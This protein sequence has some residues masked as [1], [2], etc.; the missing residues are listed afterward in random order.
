MVS[1]H[2]AFVFSSGILRSLLRFRQYNGGEWNFF[3]YIKGIENV[4]LKIQK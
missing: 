3:F 1:S 4:F 2:V